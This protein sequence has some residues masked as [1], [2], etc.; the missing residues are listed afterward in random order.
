MNREEAS[1]EMTESRRIYSLMIYVAVAT[2][3]FYR[4]EI[5]NTEPGETLGAWAEKN[6]QVRNRVFTEILEVFNYELSD[7]QMGIAI[8]AY[9]C[10]SARIEVTG[11]A[12]IMVNA[13]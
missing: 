13:G 1:M 2:F 6:K 11:P 8:S 12:T 3:H 4:D 7:H 5:S 10:P 9:L